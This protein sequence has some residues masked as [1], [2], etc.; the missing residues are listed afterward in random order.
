VIIEGSEKQRS[1]IDR[2]L[3]RKMRT[4]KGTTILASGE[5]RENKLSMK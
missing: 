3:Q 5:H 1:E 2:K 4:N